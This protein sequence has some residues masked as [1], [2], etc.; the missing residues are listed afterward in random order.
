MKV[1]FWCPYFRT[2]G[3]EFL[4]QMCHGARTH[5]S[6]AFMYYTD[7]SDVP[8]P[9]A[10]KL[11]DSSPVLF[12]EYSLVQRAFEIE[13]R[14]E[15]L[16]V[17]PEVVTVSEI[18]EKYKSIRVVVA[19]L[20]ITSGLP[21]L[22]HYLSFPDVTHVFQSFR[23]RRDV[24][25]RAKELGVEPRFFDVCDYINAEYL[26]QVWDRSVKK[27]QIAWN[28]VKDRIAG[29]LGIPGV[30]LFG[31]SREKVIETLKETKVYVDCGGHPGRDR[32]PREAAI[33]GCIVV[34]NTA[35]TA[36]CFEDVPLTTK[37]LTVEELIGHIKN[38]FERYDELLEA[39]NAYAQ[40]IRQEKDLC[41]RQMLT[42]LKEMQV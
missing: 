5:G 2:G 40:R 42:F 11:T 9:L 34:T 39:Q 13:D 6:Q 19:W 8:H 21:R 17:I 26:N 32:I 29:Q 12:P 7:A 10:T 30:P 16:L 4:H 3:P 37:A 36:E 20:S 38:G 25:A 27:N 23:A 31:M 24:L 35:G 18:R 22:D 33:L 14:P 1:Y 28:P 41:L 15:N